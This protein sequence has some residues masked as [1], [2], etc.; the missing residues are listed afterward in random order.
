MAQPRAERQSTALSGRQ[1]QGPPALAGSRSDPQSFLMGG[2]EACL[3]HIFYLE[4]QL[5]QARKAEINCFLQLL[6]LLFATTFT[7]KIED[8]TSFKLET[9]FK[10][11]G[12]AAEWFSQSLRAQNTCQ[13]GRTRTKKLSSSCSSR[14]MPPEGS[15]WIF[16]PP[17]TRLSDR[18]PS[19]SRGQSQKLFLTCPLPVSC[20]HWGL[21]GSRAWGGQIRRCPPWILP[22][23]HGGSSLPE[24]CFPNLCLGHDSLSYRRRVWG[25]NEVVREK[26]PA[27]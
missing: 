25:V 1:I 21:Q 2:R 16:P 24:P 15:A 11:S 4:G 22:A 3:Y 19:A 23:W 8:S 17:T 5:Q 26:A 20:G 27:I 6:L 18:W 14:N 10:M 12:T 13:A 7:S 9:D